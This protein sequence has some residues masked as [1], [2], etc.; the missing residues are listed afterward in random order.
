MAPR[1]AIPAL[2][3]AALAAGAGVGPDAR[4]LADAI[5]KRYGASDFDRVESIRFTYKATGGEEDTVRHWTWFP[6]QDSVLFRGKDVKGVNL[7]AAYCRRNKFSLSSQ[8]VA[9]IDRLFAHDQAWF[10]F[11]LRLAG[12]TGLEL[13]PARDGMLSVRDS[14]AESTYDLA[15]GPDGT[16]GKWIV[17]RNGDATPGT[18]AEWSRP[19]LVDGLPV[20]LERNGKK[21]F[22][23][24]FIDVKVTGLE[25]KR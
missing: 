22:K 12:D 19:K 14:A 4:A 7:Q 17:H 8:T 2:L 5:A 13:K 18:E 16:I 1:I 23:I 6:K 20:S 15:A 21:G 9:G 3:L 10:L 11:P 25:S 24:R